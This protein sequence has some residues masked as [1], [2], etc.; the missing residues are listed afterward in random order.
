MH[1]SSAQPSDTQH[2]PDIAADGPTNSDLVDSAPA[3]TWLFLHGFAGSSRQWRRLAEFVPP[4][5]T[6]IAPDL[7]GHGSNPDLLSEP[8]AELS[9]NLL[10]SFGAKSTKTIY[11]VIGH[12]LGGLVAAV[13]AVQHP[14]L[15]DHVV[16]ISTAAKLQ[17][18][19]R[20]RHELMTGRLTRATVL[21]GLADRGARSNVADAH[22]ELGADSPEGLLWRDAHLTRLTPDD[23]VAW[24]GIN[25]Y[26]AEYFNS[27]SSPTLLVTT[28]GDRIVSPRRTRELA[29]E[30]PSSFV[31]QLECAGHYPH[32]EHPE[33]LWRALTKATADTCV[34]LRQT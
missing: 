24:G 31:A 8:W 6:V 16:L 12:S 11:I 15:F 20:L 10:G 21:G 25:A 9:N 13:L 14:H 7:P 28:S 23:A 29:S 2:L 33:L 30:I 19:P 3:R 32:L 27:L 1:Y 4:G 18:H 26:P 17:L 5:D 34:P 22:A